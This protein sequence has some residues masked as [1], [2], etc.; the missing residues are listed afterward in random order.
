MKKEYA[1]LVL[2]SLSSLVTRAEVE[3]YP[4][5]NERT[6]Y[7]GKCD[8]D[9][10]KK[11]AHKWGFMSYQKELDVQSQGRCYSTC[12]K[13]AELSA[14]EAVTCIRECNDQQREQRLNAG[15]SMTTGVNALGAGFAV[16]RSFWK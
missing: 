1:I 15:N 12:E 11:R 7:I 8:S 6:H 9:A 2:I 3:V 4:A 16:L 13:L 14:S 10:V 5:N